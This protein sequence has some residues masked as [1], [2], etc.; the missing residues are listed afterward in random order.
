[1]ERAA[2][3]TGAAREWR[4]ARSSAVFRG[5]QARGEERGSRSKDGGA[6]QCTV[7]VVVGALATLNA[8]AAQVGELGRRLVRHNQQL[9]HCAFKIY[10]RNVVH[11]VGTPV[12][13][14]SW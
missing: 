6:A 10:M 11:T 7:V 4:A 13:S 14:D 5:K 3:A 12:S 1:M 9:K 2:A 8:S